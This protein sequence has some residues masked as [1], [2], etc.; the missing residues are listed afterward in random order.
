MKGVAEQMYHFLSPPI[1]CLVCQ[2]ALIPPVREH[3]F[4]VRVSFMHGF[5]EEEEQPFIHK[6]VKTFLSRSVHQSVTQREANRQ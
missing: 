5:M 2:R 6:Q 1:E 4:P 3:V